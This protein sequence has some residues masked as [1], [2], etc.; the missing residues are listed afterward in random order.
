M[1]GEQRDTTKNP[2]FQIPRSELAVANLH[3]SRPSE[4]REED[5]DDNTK[6]KTSPAQQ[7]HHTIL[8]HVYE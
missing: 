7:F 2:T 4:E 6:K 1:K 3:A 5:D 8:R